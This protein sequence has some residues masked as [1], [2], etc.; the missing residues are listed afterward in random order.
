V[1][2]SNPI[3]QPTAATLKAIP[4]KKLAAVTKRKRI[5]CS[6]HSGPPAFLVSFL[7]VAT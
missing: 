4:T 2:A 3:T 7:L 1:V 5:A 6:L